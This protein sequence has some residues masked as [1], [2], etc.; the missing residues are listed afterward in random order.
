[1]QTLQYEMNEELKQKAEIE[2][3]KHKVDILDFETFM[4]DY[5]NTQNETQQ[6]IENTK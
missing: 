2:D 3:L 6:H 1:M 4:E 5:K